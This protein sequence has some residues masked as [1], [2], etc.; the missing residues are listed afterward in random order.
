[1]DPATPSIQ[2]IYRGLAYTKNNELLIGRC[3]NTAIKFDKQNIKRLG[4]KRQIFIQ[5][6]R[7]LFPEKRF[8]FTR[9]MRTKFIS[10]RKRINRFARKQLICYM[11][12]SP[13]YNV[14]K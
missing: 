5:A 6:D 11:S 10:P 9:E 8:Y 14:G 3:Q 1:M 12:N 13:G 2:Q 4:R 7:A